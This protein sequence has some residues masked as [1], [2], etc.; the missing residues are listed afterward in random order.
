MP[1]SNSTSRNGYKRPRLKSI[2]FNMRNR[3]YNANVS[4][5]RTYG[6]MGVRVCADWLD[7]AKFEAWAIA[8]GYRDDLTI[9]RKDFDGHYEP[10]NCC[11]IPKREQSANQRTNVRIRAFGEEKTKSEWAKDPRCVVSVATLHYRLKEGREPEEAMTSPE[12]SNLKR[13]T[14]R[15]RH[16]V[17]HAFGEEKIVAQWAKDP[18]CGVSADTLHQ[19]LQDG[20]EAERAI[21]TPTLTKYRPHKE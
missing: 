15:G 6:A 12:W 5:F 8:S 21:A 10:D 2:W 16:A 7:Y 13:S 1:E 17:V 20:W 9:E 19:R 11:W 4:S 14:P 18:R 3:C